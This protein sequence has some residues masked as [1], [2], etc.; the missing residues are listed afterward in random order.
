MWQWVSCALLWLL[1]F[2]SSLHLCLEQ[3]LSWS[4]FHGAL[5]FV[6][7]HSLATPSFV[8]SCAL[9]RVCTACQL[10]LSWGPAM[11]GCSCHSSKLKFR[12]VT[13]KEHVFY[14]SHACAN[15]VLCH[16][17]WASSSVGNCSRKIWQNFKLVYFIRW[18]SAL[19]LYYWTHIIIVFVLTGAVSTGILPYA[20]FAVHLLLWSFVFSYFSVLFSSILFLSGL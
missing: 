8:D 9:L 10:C 3:A 4:S 17:Y 18:D 19:I 5:W 1:P 16:D 6:P 13:V 12:Q 15:E 2:F 14:L 7:S 11:L 20:T